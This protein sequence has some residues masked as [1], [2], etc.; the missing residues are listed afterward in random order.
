MSI[1]A[2]I[3]EEHHEAFIVW[4]YA[5]QHGIIP[6]RENILFHVDEHSDMGTPRFNRSI[7]ELNGDIQEIKDFTYSELG[8]A[9][10]IIPAVYKSIFNKVYWIRQ[11]HRVEK[12]KGTKM[13]VRSYNQAGKRLMSGKV[14]DLKEIKEDPDRVF[15]DYH[16]EPIQTVPS[17]K[18]VVLD[19]DLDYFSCSGN[20]NELN[21]L[22]LEI[23]KEEYDNFKKN[24]YHRLRYFGIGKVD[25]EIKGEKYF[26]V[27]NNYREIYPNEFRVSENEI[28]VRIENFVNNIITKSVKPSIISICRSRYSGYTPDDQWK[29]IEDTLLQ[30]LNNHFK[31]EVNNVENIK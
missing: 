26:Y 20:P 22:Y 21:E 5:I 2:F 7:H 24:N 25:A 3:I 18:R 23:T 4:N 1:P 12:T 30:H 13:Y 28:L 9:G 16:L 14:K 10:F 29:Y 15:F 17:K 31:I 6:P 8:I 27:L 11:K 19:I